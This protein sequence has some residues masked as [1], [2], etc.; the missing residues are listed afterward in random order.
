VPLPGN[1]PDGCRFSPRCP[2]VAPQCVAASIDLR[3]ASPS[4]SARCVRVEELE[5]AGQ[6][7]E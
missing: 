1:M 5:L 4:R 7:S 2:H 3:Q 6:L